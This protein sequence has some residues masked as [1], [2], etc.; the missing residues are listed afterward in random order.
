MRDLCSRFLEDQRGATAVEYGLLIS[1]IA[2]AIIGGLN[3]I[4]G[5]INTKFNM[6]AT[7]LSG[8]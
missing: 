4:S 6:V 5:N 3:A 7:T 1:L 2:L 8:S